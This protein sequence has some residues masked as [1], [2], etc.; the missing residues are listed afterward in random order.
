MNQQSQPTGCTAF[1]CHR[2]TKVIRIHHLETMNVSNLETK[3]YNTLYVKVFLNIILNVTAIDEVLQSLQE[4]LNPLGPWISGDMAI[5]LLVVEMKTKDINLMMVE[6]QALGN[7]QVQSHQKDSSFEN[8]EW[9][10]WC[11]IKKWKLWPASC[12]S[13]CGEHEC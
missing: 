8:H 3:R 2:I 5:H 10:Q 1:W 12:D 9:C 13:S 11:F 6:E 4:S 7:C